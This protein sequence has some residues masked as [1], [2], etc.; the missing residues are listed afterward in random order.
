MLNIFWRDYS[1]RRVKYA[2]LR[3]G[4]RFEINTYETH[5]WEFRDADTSDV[6]M[7]R[8]GSSSWQKIYF[9]RA[10]TGDDVTDVQ[11]DIPSKYFIES[12]MKLK[13]PYENSVFNRHVNYF[14]RS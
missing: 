4:S 11:I 3:P 12:M 1:G 10:W 5:P 7:A 2:S 13:V 8:D 6:L 9:P 14:P